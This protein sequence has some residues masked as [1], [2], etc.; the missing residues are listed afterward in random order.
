MRALNYTE[1]KFQNTF[2]VCPLLNF[3][4][5]SNNELLWSNR[6]S[7]LEQ[8]KKNWFYNTTSRKIWMVVLK[9]SECMI[10]HTIQIVWKSYGFG[11]L[12]KRTETF[13]FKDF[14]VFSLV[15]RRMLLVTCKVEW[16]WEDSIYKFLF[17]YLVN[18]IA[19]Y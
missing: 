7:W 4:L 2:L 16:N 6:R 10:W 8:L 12:Y 1:K 9:T 14:F 18:Y 3:R 11:F 13:H 5:F 15:N 19:F 17:I